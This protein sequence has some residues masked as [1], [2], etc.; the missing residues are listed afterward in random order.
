MQGKPGV[1]PQPGKFLHT[2][3]SYPPETSRK[4]PEFEGT[5][6]AF[7]LKKRSTLG[8]IMVE[9][10]TSEQNE[11]NGKPTVWLPKNAV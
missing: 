4:P 7:S 3:Q 6:L 5:P 11:S 1:F 8:V 10:K 9:V 2:S